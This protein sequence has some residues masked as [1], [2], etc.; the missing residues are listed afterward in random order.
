MSTGNKHVLWYDPTTKEE[1]KARRPSAYQIGKGNTAGA[2]DGTQGM[3]DPDTVNFKTTVFNKVA[4]SFSALFSDHADRYERRKDCPVSWTTAGQ[5]GWLREE[6]DSQYMLME[7]LELKI[8][9]LKKELAQQQELIKAYEVKVA[10]NE[11]YLQF[12][13]HWITMA[14]VFGDVPVAKDRMKWK[15]GRVVLEED[16]DEGEAMGEDAKGAM[17]TGSQAAS[18]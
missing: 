6:Q 18:Q 15:S 9:E 11:E 13:M 8:E 17:A 7:E 5:I 3:T 12:C 1:M 10:Q 14:Q 16:K 4:K 2:D